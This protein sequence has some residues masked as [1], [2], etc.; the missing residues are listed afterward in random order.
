[1]RM[2]DKLDSIRTMTMTYN[3]T[4]QQIRTIQ[5]TILLF[6]AHKVKKNLKKKKKNP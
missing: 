1:M 6:Q 2:M 3:G 5:S 4:I